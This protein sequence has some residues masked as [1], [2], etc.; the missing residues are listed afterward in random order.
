MLVACTPMKTRDTDQSEVTDTTRTLKIGGKTFD[1]YTLW[2]C[3][4]YS[5]D[6]RLVLELVKIEIPDNETPK[7]LQGTYVGLI[8]FDDR[9][10]YA[11][12]MYRREGINHRWDWGEGKGKGDYTFII[13]PDGTGLYYDFTNVK[14]GG[15]TKSKDYFKCEKDYE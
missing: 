14:Q 6:K 15:I 9:E 2:G 5:G 8:L 4:E 11:G 12:G 3:R 1:K 13:K 7:E 10:D